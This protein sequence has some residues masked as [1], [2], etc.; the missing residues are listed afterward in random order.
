MSQRRT[1]L[2]SV[3]TLMSGT[4][5]AQAITFATSFALTRLYAPAEFGHYSIFIG[6]AGVLAAAST[7]A[8]DRIVL[9]ARC[10]REAR[11]A[12][13]AALVLSAAAAT[14][15]AIAGVVLELTGLIRWLPLTLSDLALFVPM[16]MV[17]YAGAQVFIYSGLRHDHVRR[18]AAFKVAQ[19]TT[20][21]IIQ[22]LASQVKS[23]PG[24][25]IG[26]IAGW[27]I[28]LVAGIRWRQSLGQLSRDLRPRTLKAIL[29]R[30]WRYP[31]YVMPNEVIDNLSN[32]TPLFLIGTFLSLAAAG[33]Y[34]VA[35]M[36][37]SAPAAVLGQAVGQVF[38]QYLNRHGDDPHAVRSMMFRIWGGMALVGIVPFGAILVFGP[39]IFG[40]AFGRSWVEAG[41]VAQY[42]APLIYVRFISSPTSTIYLKLNLQR[43]Q[44]WFCVA[45]AGYRTAA[46]AT[47]AFGAGIGTM[48]TIHVMIEIVAI[49]AYNLVALRRLGFPIAHKEA[50]T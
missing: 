48:I 13:T 45:A 38:L 6:Y 46:Y 35:L 14:I 17:S 26:N 43:E 8:M 27:V 44:W 9:L 5:A 34:G 20:M 21:S 1:F 47:V 36:L 33:H 19:S 49:A 50:T 32:Q 39:T 41:Q 11:Q 18:L 40:F 29:R 15:V 10:D 4:V 2:V 16:F 42:L 30:Y 23:I 7:G 28:L 22:M 37:L 24:L 3:S 31:R 12:A 25:I